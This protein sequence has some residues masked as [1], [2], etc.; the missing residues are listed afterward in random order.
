MDNNNA[1]VTSRIGYFGG[2][3]PKNNPDN[4]LWRFSYENDKT[5]IKIKWN[6]INNF[7]YHLKMNNG[8]LTCVRISL[9]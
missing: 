3:E 2:R 1:K 6:K 8:G 7:I 9:N 4:C 5:T